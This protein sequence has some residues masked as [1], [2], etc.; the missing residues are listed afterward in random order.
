MKQVELLRV[1]VA[2]PGDVQAE[3][4]SLPAI[5][6][7]LNRGVAADRALRLELYR[8]ETDAYPAFHPEGPQ[9]LI[10]PILCIQDCDI[11]IGV[12]W[13]RFGTPVNDAQ[14][15]T[16]HEI[17]LAIEAWRLKRRP[18]IMVYFSQRPYTPE[19]K[20]ET[21]Q[22]GQVLEFKTNFP[23]E[24]LW[25]HYKT[26]KE[27][28]D[29]VRNHLTQFIRNEF[30]IK[31]QLLG[32]IQNYTV[33]N[34]EGA[35]SGL[36]YGYPT[37]KVEILSSALS[38]LMEK[39]LNEIR[40]LYLKGKRYEAF[41]RVET[42]R[43]DGS[44]SNLDKMIKTGLIKIQVLY[45]LE[46][47]LNI[48]KARD[49]VNEIYVEDPDGDHTVIQGVLRLH[50]GEPEKVLGELPTPTNTD[51]L[52]LKLALQLSLG[53]RDNIIQDVQTIPE[54][55]VINAET[56]RIYALALLAKGDIQGAQIEI[57][58]ALAEQAEWEGVRIASAIIDFCS[59][60]SPAAIP[61]QFII[62]PQPIDWP[63]VKRDD[64]SIQRLRRAETQF[65]RLISESEGNRER[66][67]LFE[68]WRLACL[69]NDL[70][71]LEEATTFCKSILKNDPA[72]HRA[73]LW[74]LARDFEID[75]AA[76]EQALK[77]DVGEQYDYY[78]G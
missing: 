36:V 24:G 58:K 16:E 42:I 35:T 51:L 72:N 6:E 7:D 20:K 63:L 8:W 67:E 52:N 70:G 45:S 77:R 47:E 21:D 28:T 3:R 31:P 76:S 68:I 18:Q 10:D 4:N 54:G 73:V 22:W 5:L 33:I 49:L 60:L 27:F 75:T 26:K 17:R 48:N 61:M 38:R 56:R 46:I 44:W 57:Q 66:K 32:A 14:S 41:A 50:D 15:G 13:K 34:E 71:R 30:Q 2:S 19:S 11:L 1:V 43:N 12:F 40:E 78:K 25:W 55:I 37:A 9:G 53:R 64:E 69:S 29:I 59:S 23:K 62:W 39:E 74:A 65:A